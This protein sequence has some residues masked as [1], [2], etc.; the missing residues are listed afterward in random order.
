MKT[1]LSAV[2]TDTHVVFV[3]ICPS[4]HVYSLLYIMDVAY[5]KQLHCGFGF[6]KKKLL[7][8]LF[9]EIESLP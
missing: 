6:A 5:L 4:V 1:K 7:D 9:L 8:L 3:Y 2:F